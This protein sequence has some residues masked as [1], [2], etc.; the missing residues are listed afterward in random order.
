VLLVVSLFL[1]WYKAGGDELT[2]WQAF[3]GA[4][5]VLTVSAALALLGAVA[6]AARRTAALSVAAVALGIVPALVAAFI[7]AWRLLDPAPSGEVERAV[8][9][10]LGFAGGLGIA[11]G[12]GFG[13]RDEGP[14]RRSATRA[15]EAG[16]RARRETELLSL[17][18]D[19]GPAS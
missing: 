9:A 19:A 10:W 16:E 15:A 14:E 8:G 6:T 3:S 18:T 5:V 13:M 1:P 17:P 4:D 2:G 12:A 7:A 11:I